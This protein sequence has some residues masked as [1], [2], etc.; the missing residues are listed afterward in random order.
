[1]I[2]KLEFEQ[3]RAQWLIRAFVVIAHALFF[4]SIS[5]WS[6]EAATKKGTKKL[7]VRT[8]TLTPHKPSVSTTTI[9]TPIQ[10][11]V[12]IEPPQATPQEVKTME[13]PQIAPQQEA[14]PAKKIAE[15]VKKPAKSISTPKPK[16]VVPK[17]VERKKPAVKS[18]PIPSAKEKEEEAKKSAMIAD[19]LSSLAVSKN[20]QSKRA[21]A[22]SK[23]ETA[24]APSA[25]P[26][27]HSESLVSV[28][29]ENGIAANSYSHELSQRL[30]LLLKLPEYGE[31]EVKLTL[32]RKGKVNGVKCIKFKSTKNARYLEKKLPDITFPPFGEHFPNEQEHTFCLHLSNELNW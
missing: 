20:L 8:V 2:L 10:A 23:K 19:A 17:P 9:A 13:P 31:V 32:S 11:P 21:L 16:A 6:Y 29:D 7:L 25:I 30:K 27:L 22:A 5:Y 18:S 14:K 26:S 15:P 1:M 3:T 24:S 28:E 4:L 12:E